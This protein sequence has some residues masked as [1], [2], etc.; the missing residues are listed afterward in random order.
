MRTPRVSLRASARASTLALNLLTVVALAGCGGDGGG[1]VTG[2]G[3]NPSQT[4]ITLTLGVG[5]VR[6]VS[7]AEAG[8]LR[9]TGAQGGAEFTLIPFYG[10]TS[11]ASIATLEFSGQEL[12]ATAGPPSPEIGHPAAAG[13]SLSLAPGAPD[14]ATSFELGLRRAEGDQLTPRI[15][16]ARAAYA[17][18]VGAGRALASAAAAVPAVGDVMTLNAAAS[19]SCA[20]ESMRTGRVVSVTQRAV[21]V[22]DNENPS[23]G[24]TDAEYAAIG[25]EFDA[26]VDPLVTQF[27]GD[28]TDLDESGGR[29]TIFFTRAVNELTPAGARGVVFGYFNARDVLPKT[30][31]PACP[32]S[33]EAEV[34]YLIVPDPTGV[35]NGNRRTKET[36]RRTITGILAHE[37]QHLINA[38]RRVYVNGART[39]E[40]T[41]LNE[42]LSTIAEELMFYRVAGMSPRANVAVDAL[43]SSAAR[44]E[45]L[46]AYQVGNFVRVVDHLRYPES[47]SP[48]DNL[49]ELA[50]RGATWQFLRYAADQLGTDESV[51]WQKLVNAR[52]S[53]VANFN[54]ASGADFVTMLRDWATARYVDDAVPQAASRYQ[55]PS[56]NYRSILPTLVPNRSFPLRTWALGNGA[57]F[58][59]V[60]R[61]G[62]AAYL[63]FGVASGT[64]GTV[65]IT[66]S[67]GAAPE[68]VWF[69]VVR[70]R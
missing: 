6:T 40:E 18:S 28:P 57:P 31:D 68:A 55:Q 24:F 20:E 62:G 36:V 22:A 16:A 35:V 65:R 23:G 1:P 2:P 5:E 8:L 29:V 37:Y 61:A 69:T 48:F 34:L 47:T 7:A 53:G 27:F 3:P 52:T 63:R 59:L 50:T 66:L 14:V 12:S 21:V 46:N 10:T 4:P 41:W 19:A 58:R 51:L 30:G 26:L 38:G 9:V 45:A 33:N 11:V 60:L 25:Q 13:P 15:P 39:F 54:A 70:T 64:T 49:D 67:E 17:A 56:W 32:A 43:L 44:A 42:G